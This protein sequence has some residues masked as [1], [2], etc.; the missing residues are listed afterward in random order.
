MVVQILVGLSI[1][2][3]AIVFVVRWC[4]NIMKRITKIELKIDGLPAKIE[5]GLIKQLLPFATSVINTQNNPLSQDDIEKMRRLMVKLQN[6]T[7]TE[8]ESITLK[9]F[10][11]IEKE[12]AEKKNNANLLL[13]IGIALAA[14]ALLFTISK[15]D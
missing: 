6:N 12:E 1:L 8:A 13:A 7:I 9:G 11:E 5:G 4:F 2:S 15:K 14:I 10:L 3:A